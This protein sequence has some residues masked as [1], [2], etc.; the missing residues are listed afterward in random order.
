V[1][2]RTIWRRPVPPVSV[3]A[4]GLSVV[5]LALAATALYFSAGRQGDDLARDASRRFAAAVE[6]LGSPSD[7]VRASGVFALES[8][9]REAPAEQ[10]IVT[11]VL[12]AFVRQYATAPAERSTVDDAARHPAVDVQAALTVL[13]RRDV[14][15]DRPGERL[16]L[17]GAV[18][19]GASWRDARLAGVILTGA[20]LDGADLRGATLDGADLSG[21]DLTGADLDR[22]S[23]RG[24]TLTRANLTNARI[25][26]AILDRATLSGAQMPGAGLDGTGLVGATMVGVNLRG[27]RLDATNLS[28]ANLTDADLS[29]AYLGYVTAPGADLTRARLVGSNLIDIDLTEAQLAGTNLNRALLHGA[30]LN[31]TRVTADQIS[32]AVLSDRTLLPAAMVVPSRPAPT[33]AD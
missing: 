6:L 2:V 1:N 31:R 27:A 28:A 9:L 16:D 3:L 22:A 12:T 5:A 21:A 25:N 14:R 8:V 24:T 11:A 17:S 30:T 10:P 19:A 32:C 13:G 4:L 20:R 26:L 18:L 15:W 23:M 7:T 29:E 33:C